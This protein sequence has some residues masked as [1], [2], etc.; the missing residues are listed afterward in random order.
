MRALLEQVEYFKPYSCLITVYLAKIAPGS[1]LQNA[2]LETY[3]AIAS[4][5]EIL[6][7]NSAF[8]HGSRVESSCWYK[9]R[10]GAYKT[11]SAAETTQPSA[12]CGNHYQ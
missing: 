6:R 1:L 3:T 7:L 11:L 12:L 8:Q 5:H 4:I 9:L 10:L 2:L